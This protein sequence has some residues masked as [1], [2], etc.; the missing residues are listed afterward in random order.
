MIYIAKKLGNNKYSVVDTSDSSEEVL[1]A[2]SIVEAVKLGVNVQGVSIYNNRVSIKEWNTESFLA[3]LS[4]LGFNDCMIN[5]KGLVSACLT[6]ECLHGDTLNIPEGLE[7]LQSRGDLPDSIKNVIIPSTL[8]LCLDV[9]SNSSIERA[10]VSEG[11]KELPEATFRE[12][13][14]LREVVLPKSLTS[15]G[16]YAF[17]RCIDLQSIKL[18]DGLDSIGAYC[19]CRCLALKEVY[20]PSSVRIIGHGC[21]TSS[22]I[23]NLSVSKD[24]LFEGS[25]RYLTRVYLTRY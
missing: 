23:Q 21:F 12:C 22:G 10:V 14:K 2:E 5:N 24:T 9:L 13:F 17:N 15:L 4:L 16:S 18:P 8:K 11:L 6:P 19:F 7:V 1:D 25:S 20:V 3:E